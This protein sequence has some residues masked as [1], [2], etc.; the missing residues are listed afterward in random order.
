MANR[1]ISNLHTSS[2]PWWWD[3]IA[4]RANKGAKTL[5]CA[6]GYIFCLCGVALPIAR[7]QT[8]FPMITHVNPVAIERGKTT[9]VLVEG[10]MNFAGVYK[11]LFE[12][13]GIVADVPA[14]PAK[15]SG[16]VRKL[17]LKVTVTPDAALGVREFRVASLLGISSVGQL[18]IVDEPVVRETATNNTTSQAQPIM[19]PCV[20]AGRI[21]AVEDVDYFKFDAKEGDV[22]TFELCCARL[23]DRIHDLQKHAKPMLTLYDGDGRELSANDH[24]YFADPMLSYGI[25]KT[26][27][28]Y[29]QVRDSTYDGDARWVYALLATNR[30]Y[31][32]HVFPMAGK[33]GSTIDVEPI[34]SAK[35]VE[36]RL[37]LV[38][39]VEPGVRQ[40]QLDVG[41]RKTNPVTFL[42]SNLPQFTEHEPN[43]TP[44][45]ATRV[46]VPAGINGRIGKN[47][48]LDHYI[49]AAKKRVPLRIELKARRFGTLL[50]SQLHGIL[51]V[52]NAKGAVLAGSDATHGQEASLVFTPPADGDYVLR[53]RDL[54]SKGGDAWIYHVE[55]D[56]SRPDFTLRC[57][58]DKAMIGPGASTAWFVQVTRTGGFTGPVQVEVRGL[59][60][61]VTASPLTISPAMTQGAI[62]ITAAPT[63]APAAAFVQL[64]ATGKVKS[65]DGKEE[66]LT[67]TVTPI[68]EIY[69]PGG[70]R[71]K[72][73]VNRQAVAVTGPSDILKVDVS[74]TRVV[75]KPGEE[76]KIDIGVQRRSDYDK[77]VTLDVLLQHLGSVFGNPLPPGVTVVP[78][79]SKTLLGT[80]SK[81]HIVLKAA[82]NAADIE[83][84][85]IAVL[86]NVSVNFVVKIPYSS[87]LILLSVRK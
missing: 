56:V 87:P 37:P 71:A 53:V 30:P 2:T 16:A 52:M 45:T 28:Y 39:P 35:L 47:R 4:R 43:D 49:F 1:I 61:D 51:E 18:L 14:A 77:G 21:E 23:Q 38:V 64:V 11:A 19:L 75:L 57:D 36:P 72:F 55:L 46:A 86:A 34:G 32:S 24:F 42:V 60:R 17:T 12:G 40:L 74:T 10:Q 20:V 82:P 78:G 7:A 25:A 84:V 62:V 3:E 80:G 48:D 5:A 31:A 22:V 27:T 83:D 44:A 33:A 69:S 26:G 50:N 70:G 68:Q 85:P 6:A 73:E 59:P 15:Q 29:L 41:G 54:N 13:T 65:A 79:K 66:T 9:E 58:P 63:A 67:C 81:G 8:S 76:V